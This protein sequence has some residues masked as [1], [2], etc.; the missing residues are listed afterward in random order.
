MRKEVPIIILLLI[1]F[2]GCCSYQELVPKVKMECLSNGLIIFNQD[3][4]YY[5]PKDSCCFIQESDKDI[6]GLILKNRICADTIRCYEYEDMERL[7]AVKY[8]YRYAP[9]VGQRTVPG[10]NDDTYF[11]KRNS[12]YMLFARI[13]MYSYGEIDKRLDRIYPWVVSIAGQNIR[14]NFVD[15]RRVFFDIEHTESIDSI[16][17]ADFLKKLKSAD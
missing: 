4:I 15:G 13:R 16:Q 8:Y 7:K 5:I 3:G 10:V 12:C 14:A 9:N 11:I 1:F 6:D 2:G 17:L